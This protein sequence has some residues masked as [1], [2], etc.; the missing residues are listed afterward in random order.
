MVQYCKSINI[1]YPI[2][3]SKDKNHIIISID[4]KRAFDKFDK[5]QH[6][7]LIKTLSKWEY[8]EHSST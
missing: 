4:A 6:P 7:F 8:R 2:N 5:V 1:I 3:K